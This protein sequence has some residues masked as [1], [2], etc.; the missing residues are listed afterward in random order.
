MKPVPRAQIDFLLGRTHVGT[1]NSKVVKD[2]YRRMKKDKV[3][4][5]AYRK[6]CYRYALKVHAK[7]LALYRY[8]M[9]GH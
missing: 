3:F 4:T 5:K 1:A 8:V 6:R 9:R 7:N 2:L